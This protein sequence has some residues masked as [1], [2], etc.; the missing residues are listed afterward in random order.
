MNT[1]S[2]IYRDGQIVWKDVEIFHDR[3]SLMFVDTR[4]ALYPE[5]TLQGVHVQ[6]CFGQQLLELGVLAI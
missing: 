5:H 4:L 1:G 6:M 3:V 2:V